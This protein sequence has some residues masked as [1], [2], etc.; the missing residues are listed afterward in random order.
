MLQYR[1]MAAE[2]VADLALRYAGGFVESFQP[3]AHQTAERSPLRRL[4]QQA[5]VTEHEQVR[6]STRP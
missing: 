5:Q 2:L 1:R 6:R 3:D 4:F